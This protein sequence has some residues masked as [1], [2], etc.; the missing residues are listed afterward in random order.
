MH[1]L[2]KENSKTKKNMENIKTIKTSYN[3]HQ[4]RRKIEGTEKKKKLQIQTNTKN[5]TI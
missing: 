1:F 2:L 5:E 3:K 4:T